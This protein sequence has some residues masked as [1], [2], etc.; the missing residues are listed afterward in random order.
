MSGLAPIPE[1]SVRKDAARACPDRLED[2]APLRPEW[3]Y[4]LTRLAAAMAAHT[5]TGCWTEGRSN[6]PH[7]PAVL[8]FSHQNWADPAYVLAAL[9][10]RPRC[11]FFGPEQEDMRRGVRNRLMRW[12]GI[13]VPYQPG[14]RG[15]VA[16]TRRAEELLGRGD[17][18]AIAGEGRIHAG[19]A[20][21]LPLL[22][23]PAY[24]ALRAGVPLV[25]VAINGTSWLGFRRRVRVRI[26]PPLEAGGGP[27]ERVEAGAVVAL[28]ARAQESLTLLAADFPDRPKSRWL[29]GWL[30]ELFNEWPEG[31][32]PQHDT[33]SSPQVRSPEGNPRH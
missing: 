30:T 25:P 9:R 12:A 3:R 15:L 19:E 18:V 27:G 21:V 2:Q 33:R 7:G 5:Y 16:A 23:G 32:R 13:A 29:G 22:E 31:A 24:L 14:R 26:G 1:D 6:I 28:T 11:H 8:C 10:P 4:R 17:S 20:A